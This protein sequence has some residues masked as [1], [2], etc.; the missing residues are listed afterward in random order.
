MPG[1]QADADALYRA[2]VNLVANA[3]DAMPKGG[4]LT[5]MVGWDDRARPRLPG[6]AGSDAMVRIDIQDDGVGIPASNADSVFNPFF[7]TKDGGTGLGLALTHKIVD[8]HGGAIDFT[9]APGRGTTFRIVLP[10]R[11]VSR[12]AEDDTRRD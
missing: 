9:S 5:V 3:L 7:T 6:R 12:G 2:L 10:I 8:D 11:P 1:I 4:H